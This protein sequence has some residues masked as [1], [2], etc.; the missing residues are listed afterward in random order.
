VNSFRQR[1]PKFDV[2]KVRQT[3]V[4]C[5]KSST[6]WGSTKCLFIKV[7]QTGVRRTGVRRTGVRQ[8][9]VVPFLFDSFFVGLAL[10]KQIENEWLR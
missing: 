10:L 6:Y 5:C 9:A 3:G 8:I 4:G 2:F 7:Q 1:L